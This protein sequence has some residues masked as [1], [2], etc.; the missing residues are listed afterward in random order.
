MGTM[1][2]LANKAVL[3]NRD[4]NHQLALEHGVEA[5]ELAEEFGFVETRSDMNNELGIGHLNLGNLEAALQRSTR[6]IE[7]LEG[8][9]FIEKRKDAE[10]TLSE[11]YSAM[12]QHEDALVHFETYSVLKDSIFQKARSNQMLRLEEQYKSEKQA[13]EIVLLNAESELEE[14][15]IVK[16]PETNILLE[17]RKKITN[18]YDQSPPTSRVKQLLWMLESC[19]QCNGVLWM[20]IK[21]PRQVDLECKS[22]FHPKQISP[23]LLGQASDHDWRE[24]HS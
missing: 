21:D 6:A 20:V 19:S 12:G 23:Y 15:K 11:I 13:K 8:T 18:I 17:Q 7:I 24:C 9:T 16:L 3:E 1:S 2:A 14:T 22:N 4:A 5:L 10:K